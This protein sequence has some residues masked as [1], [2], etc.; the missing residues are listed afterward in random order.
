[1]RIEF[2]RLSEEAP[3]AQ[4]PLEQI[5]RVF[6][7]APPYAIEVGGLSIRT[8]HRWFSALPPQGPGAPLAELRRWPGDTVMALYAISGPLSSTRGSHP[9][10]PGGRF[11][12]DLETAGAQNWTGTLRTDAGEFRAAWVERAVEESPAYLGALLIPGD[13]GLGDPAIDQ[14]LLE[15]R[16]TLERVRVRP[17]AWRLQSSHPADRPLQ[18]PRIGTPPGTKDEEVDPWQVARASGFT[19]GMP[20]GLRA[21]P[22]DGAVPAPRSVPG[23]RLWLRGRYTD[24]GGTPVAIGDGSRAGYVAEIRPAEE[25]WTAGELEPLGAPGAQRINGQPFPIAAERA[26]ALQARAERWSEEGFDGQ[27]LVF[28]LRFEQ[29]GVEIGLPVLE[30]G[31]SASLFW[32]PLTWRDSS[33]APA[34]PPVDPA[35]RFGIRFD[36]LTPAER[37]SQPWTEGSL[38]VPGLMAELPRGWFPAASLRS[39]DGYPVRIV[40]SDGASVGQLRRLDEGD[41]PSVEAPGPGWQPVRRSAGARAAGVFRHADG[42][43]LYVSKDGAVFE[44]RLI[45]AGDE[46]FPQLWKRLAE[47]VRLTR[48]GR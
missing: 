31:R 13:A 19:I 5:E 36:R 42:S 30:G 10:I 39:S 34:P 28:R 32:M 2:A 23:G 41:L 3:D 33:H 6:R 40:D 7:S 24:S 35:E 37:K 11:T 46:D 25:D 18:L 45:D 43:Y 12:R 47:S 17:A 14:L 48:S 21:R 9:A 22:L 8:D 44:L 20:P 38:I 1:M 15:L 27:W 16:A 4:D 26:A 29:Y